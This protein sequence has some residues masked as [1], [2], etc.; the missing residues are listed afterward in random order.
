MSEEE[1]KQKLTGRFDFLREKVELRRARRLWAQVDM[2][3]FREVFDYA[4]RELGFTMLTAITGLDDGE[5]YGLIYH[6]AMD[7]GTM[8]MIKTSIPKSDPV[9]VTVTDVFPAAE[10]YEREM[11]DLLGVKVKGLSEGNR[12]P[13]PDDWPADVYPLRKDFDPSIL[14]KKEGIK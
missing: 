10:I 3:K 8:L 13:L 5:R 7:G 4:V 9:L 14:D 11:A 1:I 6:M 12:Y 2:D